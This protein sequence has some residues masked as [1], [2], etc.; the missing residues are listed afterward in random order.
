MAEPASRFSASEAAFEGFSLIRHH[1][2]V[3]VGWAGFNL[4]A[5][6]MLVVLVVMTEFVATA[7]GGGGGGRALGPAAIILVG[8]VLL[9]AIIVGAVFRLEQ[10]PQETAFFYLR[11][12]GGE[13]RLVIIWLITLVAAG[14]LISLAEAAAG[15]LHQAAVVSRLFAVALT[16]YF[17][18]RIA[19]AAPAS[20][21]EGRL[22]FDSAWRLSRGRR[23]LGLLGMLLLTACLIGMLM[24]AVIVAMSLVAVVVG[25][26]D[27]VAS[28]FTGGAEAFRRHPGVLVLYA[29]VEIVL[30]PLLWV[31]ATAP[32]IAA[33]R[34]LSGAQPQS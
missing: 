30:T 33:Y 13:L 2:R 8:G 16:I 6:V 14:V 28:L 34:T 9:Q 18:V 23:T 24:L 27:A 32:L 12:G 11:L 10:S 17:S 1:W 5:L 3:V 15:A 29:A 4:L 22:A 20:F 21:A 31:L 25:G 19:L 26:L 7:V